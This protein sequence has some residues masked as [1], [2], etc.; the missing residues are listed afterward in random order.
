M[1]YCWEGKL[2]QSK[3]STIVFNFHPIS[4]LDLIWEILYFADL[5]QVARNCKCWTFFLFLRCSRHCFSKSSSTFIWSRV[6]VMK[7]SQFT[8]FTHICNIINFFRLWVYKNVEKLKKLFNDYQTSSKVK[9]V[10]NEFGVFQS[11]EDN[12]VHELTN[13]LII[14][15]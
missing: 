1:D 14:S 3:K 10:K 8:I 7:P 2:I 4:C 12:W 6:I 11:N 5:S 15:T 13:L 9:N